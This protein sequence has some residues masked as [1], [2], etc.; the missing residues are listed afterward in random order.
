[1]L[2]MDNLYC[3]KADLKT[4]SDVEQKFIYKFLTSL[5]PLGLGYNSSDIRT[6]ATLK[7]YYIN[8]GSQQKYYIPDYIVLLRGLSCLIIEA[9]KPGE[10]LYQAYSEARLYANEINAKYPHNISICQKIIC[11]DGFETWV[12]YADNNKPLLKLKFE[13]FAVDVKLFN[14]F[15]EFCNKKNLDLNIN[16]VYSKI[17]GKAHFKTPISELGIV[18]DEELEENAYGRNLIFENHHIFDPDT[19]EDRKLIV[20]NAYVKSPKRDQHVEPIYK[21]LRK[22]SSPSRINS[23]LIG[24]DDSKEIVEK[25]NQT[26]LDRTKIVNSLMLLIGNAGC[27]KSTFIRYF[28]EVILNTS[29][30]DTAKNF[31]WIFI[32]MNEAPISESEVYSWLKSAVIN[33]IK[34]CHPNVDFANIETIKQIFKRKISEFDKGTGAL[35]KTNS[36]K[37]NEELYNKLNA[38]LE[39]DSYYL[40]CLIKFIADFHSKLPI[41][42]LDNCDKRTEAEQLLMFQVAQWL[43]AKYKCIVFLPIRDTTYDKYKNEPPIDT[44]VKDL[45]FRIDP[46]DL[47]KVL[48]ARFEYINRL[49]KNNPE[50]YLFNNGMRIRIGKDEQIEYFKAILNTIRNNRW[51]KTIFYNLSNGNIREAI[52]LFEDFCKSGHIKAEDIFGIKVTDGNYSLPSYKLLNALIRKNRKYYNEEFSNFT[53]LFSSNN[54][55][56]FPDPFVRV[57]I[58]LWLKSKLNNIGISGL[59]GYHKINDIVNDLQSIGHSS[60]VIVREIKKLIE[61]KLIVA[62]NLNVNLDTLIK[63]SS[64]GVLHVN[65]LSNL[66]YLAACSENILY[67]NNE[68]M[69][70]IANCLT[71]ENYLDK[72]SLYNNVTTMYE[73]LCEYKNYYISQPEVFLKDEFCINIY[74]LANI[75]S[76]LDKTLNE[77]DKI[78]NIVKIKEKYPKNSEVIC[79]VYY[80][81]NNAILCNIEDDD[82]KGFLA[83]KDHHYNHNLDVIDYNTISDGDY[84]ICKIID[85]NEIHN[86]F[87]LEYIAKI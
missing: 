5:E 86:S 68:V 9:K 42:V 14:E 20:Q 52:Q 84:L 1:M 76:A 7:G 15:L 58:L 49:I 2:N 27:G 6:K 77:S 16:N 67:R 35:L 56:D 38:W 40:E 34:N 87:N 74:N 39:D 62:E 69:V 78:L 31:D 54:S 75:K 11:S 85:Y 4:E 21:E 10:D 73:Y 81:K 83:V 44:V 29:F 43:R 26:S 22:M 64:S 80:K 82:I 48:Q 32:N 51:A 45:I 57:D 46:A 25:L 18:Q 63:I 53:N 8:K 65:L 37:Y 23:V 61:R 28:K 70:K 12:G 59:K 24:T 13:D 3:N 19:E 72:L 60:H 30:P 79:E 55:D 36:S 47:L 33:N 66:S 17:R 71:R 50:E 41:I